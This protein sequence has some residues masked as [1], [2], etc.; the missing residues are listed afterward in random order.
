MEARAQEH[1][2]F[3]ALRLLAV[4]IVIYGNGLVLTSSPPSALWGA[5]M[6]R[7]GLDMLFAISG[8]L[9]TG[10]WQRTGRLGPYLAR[11]VLRL[12]PT[13]AVCVL[14]TMLVIGPLATKL[15]LRPYLLDRMTRHYIA[16]IVLVPEL[17]LPRVFEGQQWAGTVNPMLWTLA[18][19]LLGFLVVPL[20]GALPARWRW[21]AALAV[22]VVC[23]VLS[24]LWPD[25]LPHL[26]HPLRRQVIG[27]TLVEAPFF[28]V[29]MALWFATGLIGERLWRADLAMLCF[30]ASW[31][32][33]TWLGA[34]TITLEWLAL[35]YMALC[36]GRMSMPG[37]GRL[38]PLGNP[39]YG[40]Y[41]AA[42][43]LQQLIV[44]RMPGVAHPIL[45]CFVLAL[46]AGLLSWH[47]VER[48]AMRLA[49]FRA[50]FLAPRTAAPR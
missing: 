39:S 13:L 31:V 17:W 45:A 6:P 27:D 18:P 46:L 30:A 36:F 9:A 7:I 15:P 50:G 35:P 38:G 44:A 48:P 25:L 8:F 33:A 49:T 34:W 21:R 37:L 3:N 42:F 5:P 19:G 47:L 24:L 23:A 12:F 2:N 10:S 41:L 28:L 11:R 1:G 16:N 4:G 22:A 20:F 32:M 43:P 40:A 14:A 29:G 26:P